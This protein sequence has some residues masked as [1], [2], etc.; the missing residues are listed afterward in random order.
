VRNKD[1]LTDMVVVVKAETA[2]ALGLLFDAHPVEVVSTLEHFDV[3]LVQLETLLAV[4]A[5]VLLRSSALEPEVVEDDC[6]CHL[7]LLDEAVGVVEDVLKVG[8]PFYFLFEGRLELR[9]RHVLLPFLLEQ[10]YYSLKGNV[11][12]HP[13]HELLDSRQQKYFEVRKVFLVGGVRVVVDDLLLELVNF[14]D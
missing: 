1:V 12:R 9:V 6:V 13:H 8:H 2:F 11:L 5:F 14:V 7:V 3:L 10:V 4:V